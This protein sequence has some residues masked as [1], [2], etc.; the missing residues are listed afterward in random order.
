M[1]KSL[2]RDNISVSAFLL[3]IG[4]IAVFVTAFIR[5]SSCLEMPVPKP[6]YS[7]K[8]HIDVISYV[9]LKRSAVQV[10]LKPPYLPDFSEKYTDEP[11]VIVNW[12]IKTRSGESYSGRSVGVLAPPYSSFIFSIQDDLEKEL[13]KIHS[14]Q[15]F[16]NEYRYRIIRE[17]TELRVELV[18]PETGNIEATFTQKYNPD[19]R[20]PDGLGPY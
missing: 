8:A 11:Q 15:I 3:A 18:H 4:I 1:F 13:R 7:K 6:V 10:R 20:T 2:R 5:L 17:I 12:W 19:L 16:I 14:E 9:R